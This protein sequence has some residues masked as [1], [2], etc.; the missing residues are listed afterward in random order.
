MSAIDKDI[1][2]ILDIQA[3]RGKTLKINGKPDPLLRGK[4]LEQFGYVCV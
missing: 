3:T 1:S 4:R 2:H